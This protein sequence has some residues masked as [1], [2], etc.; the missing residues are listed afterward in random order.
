M[1]SGDDGRKHAPGDHA[2]VLTICDYVVR[3]GAFSASSPPM[4]RLSDSL[5]MLARLLDLFL[6]A[7]MVGK[8][9]MEV[10]A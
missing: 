1:E 4:Y 6:E 2:E 9:E 7:G 5:N 10:L 8:L 3:P